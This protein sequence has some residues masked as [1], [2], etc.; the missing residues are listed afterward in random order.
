ME[1][2]MEFSITALLAI[3]VIDLVL[4]GDNAVVIGMAARNVPKEQQKRVILW[5]TAGAIIIRALMTLIVVW[6]LKIP[7]LH[8]AGGILLIWIAYKL[9]VDKKGHDS[10]IK[11]QNNM[12]KAIGTIIVADTVMGIDNVIAIAGASGG[13][14]LLV[15]IGL[16]IS[17]PIMIFG[18]TLVLKFIE[19]YPIIVY[20]GSGILAWTAGKMIMDEPAVH[21]AIASMPY[22]KWIVAGVVVV[23]VLLVGRFQNQKQMKLQHAKNES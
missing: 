3:I 23:L 6:L 9:V 16:L 2:G 18:S 19:R 11:A 17:I 20:I 22:V 21:N 13:S 15:I 14:F 4:A 8:L 1:F 7:G 12:A 5:G 10:N